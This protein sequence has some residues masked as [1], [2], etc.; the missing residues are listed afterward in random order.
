[1]NWLRWALLTV[2]LAGCGAL[3]TSTAPPAPAAPTAVDCRNPPDLRPVPAGA[4]EL[5]PGRI[6]F[7]YRDMHVVSRVCDRVAIVGGGGPIVFGDEPV[8]WVAHASLPPGTTE[9]TRQHLVVSRLTETGEL[10][11]RDVDE[12]NAAA[13]PYG[14]LDPRDTWEPGTYRMRI[15]VGSYVIADS[16]FVVAAGS[17]ASIAP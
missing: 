13:N 7:G 16:T 9:T 11:L 6:V 10:P 15:V 12:G 14:N 4:V 5:L 3:P 2:S 8:P 1:M 17:P